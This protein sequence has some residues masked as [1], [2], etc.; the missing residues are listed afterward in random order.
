MGQRNLPILGVAAVAGA[1]L[2]AVAATAIL[3][4]GSPSRGPAA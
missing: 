4:A 2:V 1:V 3:L